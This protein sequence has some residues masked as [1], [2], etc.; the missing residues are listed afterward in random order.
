MPASFK[1]W[2]AV[3]FGGFKSLLIFIDAEVYMGNGSQK[4]LV[5]IASSLKIGIWGSGPHIH[6]DAEVVLK[7]FQEQDN[8]VSVKSPLIF[9]DVGCQGQQW[10]FCRNVG[11]ESVTPGHRNLW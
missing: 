1:V 3:A 11:W 2:A 8:M 9:S 6:F 7:V 4:P 5:I 10:T